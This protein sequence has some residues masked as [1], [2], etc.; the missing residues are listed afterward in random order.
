M[1]RNTFLA[2][3]LHVIARKFLWRNA[4][5][6]MLATCQR[7]LP[8]VFNRSNW[9][10][11]WLKK[12]WSTKSTENGFFPY[13]TR[14]NPTNSTNQ[15][16]LIPVEHD[17]TVSSVVQCLW[18]LYHHLQMYLLLPDSSVSSMIAAKQELPTI[19]KITQSQFY[20]AYWK[21]PYYIG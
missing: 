16:R 8:I 2:D 3:S 1:R 7:T 17:L 14:K 12:C 5:K 18:F 10:R 21:P 6:P 13:R 4:W 20:T 11:S 19:W 15:K 9:A